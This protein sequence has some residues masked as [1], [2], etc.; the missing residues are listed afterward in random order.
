[1]IGESEIKS[2]LK[3]YSI[4]L[5]NYQIR[6]IK[7]TLNYIIQDNIKSVL[8]ESPTGSGKT[9]MA[10]CILRF[11]EDK[12]NYSINW[13][14]M[15]RNLLSQTEEENQSRKFFN[16]INYVSMFEKEVAQADIL[17]IDEGQHDATK[18]SANIHAKTKAKITLA[19]SATPYRADRASLF[20]Q[21]VIRDANIRML[22]RDGY[23]S[24]YNHY[25]IEDW[26]PELLAQI[27]IEEKEK[28]GKSVFFFHTYEECEKFKKI[29][30]NNN[31]KVEL[32]SG[33]SNKEYQLKKFLKDEVDVIVNMMILTEGFNCPSIKSVFCKP[34]NKGVTVQMAGRVLRLY[35]KFPI[36]NI[37]QSKFSPYPFIK[38]APASKQFIKVEKEWSELG[39]NKNI[40]KIIYKSIG[41][42]Q[43]N[44]IK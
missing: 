25:T 10:L 21:K 19:L 29:L 7:K 27:Y 37:I 13:C 15:R 41:L 14:A 30:L 42:M 43:N 1:M 23:L 9:I 24:K 20:F 40:D 35:E 34:S 32:I 3:N 31:I 33:K 22:I 12:F 4:E 2:F 38:I 8:I 36:K 26:S 18:S 5:R 28:W 16:Q 39:I 17:V 44:L 6:I 11:L